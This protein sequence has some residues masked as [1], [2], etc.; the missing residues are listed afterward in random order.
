MEWHETWE[1]L[2]PVVDPGKEP[3]V[4]VG[5]SKVVRGALTRNEGGQNCELPLLGTRQNGLLKNTGAWNSPV[6]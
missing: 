3:G 5:V 2:G 4:G 6:V 1:L